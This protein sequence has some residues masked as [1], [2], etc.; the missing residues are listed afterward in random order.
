MVPLNN[1]TVGLSPFE[2]ISLALSIVVNEIIVVVTTYTNRAQSTFIHFLQDVIIWFY[3]IDFS[4]LVE[5]II[6]HVY[7]YFL[8]A[9]QIIR[10]Y[11]NDLAA[12]FA[13]TVAASGMILV[14]KE[15]FWTIT[16]TAAWAL[17]FITFRL[18]HVE[19]QSRGGV[20][21]PIIELDELDSASEVSEEPADEVEPAAPEP[22]TVSETVEPHCPLCGIAHLGM[23]CPGF[24]L[25]PRFSVGDNYRKVP[26]SDLTNASVTSGMLRH[27]SVH[28]AD[29]FDKARKYELIPSRAECLIGAQPGTTKRG[30]TK[31]DVKH[32]TNVEE[33]VAK[34][35]RSYTPS[36]R[37]TP[38]PGRSIYKAI[39]KVYAERIPGARFGLVPLGN[40]FYNH[41][42][43]T[44][45][46]SLYNVTKTYANDL[47][48]YLPHTTDIHLSIK[49]QRDSTLG[50]SDNGRLPKR[51]RT[52]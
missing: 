29:T 4:D 8:R 52:S 43:N 13:P 27:P 21:P 1:V 36:G 25:R 51:R 9:A 14:K 7:A 31:A 19:F 42:Y 26:D 35:I 50:I 47:G 15:L 49:R 46:Y 24:P 48:D 37:T 10:P 28:G 40:G 20:K 16:I 5:D 33:R 44:L 11:M 22:P 39:Q 3:T 6:S 32:A 23:R 38:L 34:K 17:F 30:D 12:S 18:L 2:I 41:K 45:H